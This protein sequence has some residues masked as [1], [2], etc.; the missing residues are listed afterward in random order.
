MLAVRGF[1][2]AQRWLHVWGRWH[3]IFAQHLK[4]DRIMKGFVPCGAGQFCFP[5]LLGLGSTE[6]HDSA[7]GGWTGIRGDPWLRL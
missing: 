5:S 4:F 7:S 1:G 2:G 3:P 6:T